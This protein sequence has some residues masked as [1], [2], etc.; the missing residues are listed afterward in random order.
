MAVRDQ[1]IVRVWDGE[2]LINENIDFLRT[3]TKIVKFPLSK[4]VDSIIS[5]LIDTYKAVPCAGIAANQLGYNKKIFIGMKYD[6]DTSN[7]ND[8]NID[9]VKP[10][11]DN[12]EIYINPQ[13]DSKNNSSTQIG[14]EGCLSIPNIT[15]EIERYDKIKARYYNLE[16][17]RIKRPLSGFIS[18]LYQHE[19]DHLNGNLMFEN[20]LS[21]I[22]ISDHSDKAYVERM[23]TL[24]DYLKNR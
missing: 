6:I 22:Y 15:L 19:L 13:I 24:I 11:P 10:D 4:E 23:Q 14:T 8:E 17:R 21:S 2:S 12:Y 20:P 1:E 9:D 18:R 3:P 16:G 5:D 7:T